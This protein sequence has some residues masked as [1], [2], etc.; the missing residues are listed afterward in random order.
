MPNGRNLSR[1]STTFAAGIDFTAVPGGG[2]KAL[3]VSCDS[4]SGAA[5]RVQVG[6]TDGTG[7]DI[8]G[9]TD[10][11]VISAGQSQDY[12][13]YG[14]NTLITSFRY[15]TDTGSTATTGDARIMA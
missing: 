14:H 4:D 11:D 1:D 13:A 5:M 15:A 8:S 10:Y 3:T 6:R 12:I 9:S 2:C 7:H